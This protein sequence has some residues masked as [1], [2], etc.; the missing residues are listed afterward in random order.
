MTDIYHD[1]PKADLTFFLFLE[2]TTAWRIMSEEK[3]GVKMRLNRKAGA[4]HGALYLG[5][6]VCI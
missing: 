6:G 1:D 5:S 2:Q 3:A 4:D